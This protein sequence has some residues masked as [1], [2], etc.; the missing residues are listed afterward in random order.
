VSCSD[1]DEV[2]ALVNNNSNEE[3]GNPNVKGIDTVRLQSLPWFLRTVL[4]LKGDSGQG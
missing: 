2:K 1:S 3:V 4:I